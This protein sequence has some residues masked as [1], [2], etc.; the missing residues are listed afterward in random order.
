VSARH[1]EGAEQ[2]LLGLLIAG[3]G[4]QL[5]NYRAAAAVVTRA[6]FWLPAHQRCGR[7]SRRCLPP[8]RPAPTRW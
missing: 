3:Y 1:D 5:R 8:A 7:R 6:D 4:D 2:A